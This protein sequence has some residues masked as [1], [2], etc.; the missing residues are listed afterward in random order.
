MAVSKKKKVNNKGIVL[1]K[2]SNNL[3]ESRYKF[4]IWETRFFLSVLSQIRRTDEDFQVYRIWY[5]DV[6]KAF[7]LKSGDSYALLRTAAKSLMGKSFFVSYEKDGVTREQQYHIL[8]KIDYLREG[9]TSADHHEYIDVTVEQDMKP[10]L[11]ELQK[12]FTAYDLANIVKLGVYP[13]RVYELLKQYEA[14]GKRKLRIEEMKKMFEV[15]DKYRAFGD[16]FRWVVKPAVKE[17]NRYTDLLV[18]DVQKIKEGR[19][20]TALCFHFRAKETT[21]VL[22]EA[23]QTEVSDVPETEYISES[24]KQPKTNVKR[25]NTD[26]DRLLDTFMPDIVQKFGVTPSVF[27]KLPDKYSEAEIQQA[28]SVTH[29]AR[30]N[31]QIKSNIAG[32]FIKALKEGYT[33][34]KEEQKKQKAE[35]QRIRLRKAELLRQ[36]AQ[37]KHEKSAETNRIIRQL[38]DENPDLTLRAIEAL[39]NTTMTKVVIEQKE[40]QLGRDLILEDYRKDKMLRELVKGK[41]T[42]LRPAEFARMRTAADKRIQKTEKELKSLG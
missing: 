30:F 11:L 42:E 8:R 6:I 7:G 10:F 26:K 4:D 23:T 16:F 14:I 17:I 34:P 15:T 13:V 29:R 3:I 19:S 2:K 22:S 24:A 41:I 28:V 21:G 40:N 32:F 37:A 35:K 33:D 18:T 31:Q 39:R 1:I 5:K 36:I 12:N 25:K 20:V 38:T 27:M 9:E